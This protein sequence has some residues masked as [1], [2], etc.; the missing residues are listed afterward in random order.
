M[1]NLY[2]IVP[3]DIISSGDPK[4][5]MLYCQLYLLEIANKKYSLKDLQRESEL[6]YKTCRIV[7]TKVRDNINKNKRSKTQ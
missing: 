2:A 7:Q 3:E 4:R 1:S 5:I 6:S